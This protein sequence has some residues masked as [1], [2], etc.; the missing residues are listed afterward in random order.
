MSSLTKSIF[1]LYTIFILLKFKHF[2]YRG[3]DCD[4]IPVDLEIGKFIT[5]T[6]VRYINDFIEP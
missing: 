4:D 5:E 2:Y 3:K 1:Y 6:K